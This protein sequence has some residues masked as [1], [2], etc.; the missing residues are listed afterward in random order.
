MIYI[1]NHVNVL[2]LLGAITKYIVDGHLYVIVEYCR[3]GSLADYLKR[4]R[5]RFVDELLSVSEPE[6][7]YESS[8]DVDG[9]LVPNCQ[10]NSVNEKGVAGTSLGTIGRRR[11]RVSE[12]V[13]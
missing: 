9:Y 5:D 13:A 7:A 3:L 2:R 1:E 6:D 4:N 12:S 10:L 11:Y 8:V